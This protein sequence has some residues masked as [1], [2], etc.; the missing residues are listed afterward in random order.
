MAKT[1]E[2]VKG[3]YDYLPE[4][5]IIREHIKDTLKKVFVTY[6]FPPAETPIL[7]MY[8]LL[9]SKY[10]E[11]AD[12]L[13]EMYTLSDQ[14]K[15]ELGL[16]YDLTVC[17]SK[18]ISSNAGITLPLK[19]YEI[20]KVFRD[21]PVKLGRNREFTQCDVDVVGISSLL[22]EAE[23]MTLTTE[24]YQALG[25][26]VEILYNNRKLLS[27]VIQSVLGDME[28]DVLRKAIMLIDKLAK[29]TADELAKEFE[30]IGYEKKKFTKVRDLLLLDFHGLKE[31]LKDYPS[32]ELME[33]GLKEVE[34]LQAYTKD[35]P[36]E[37]T[38][39]FAPYLAR[40][41]D[42]YTGT[43]WEIFLKDRNMKGHDFNVSL[44]GGGRYDH[45]I[46]EFVSDGKEYP[47]VGMSFGLDVI[48]EV[49]KIKEE[50]KP[51]PAID[52][53]VMP[54]GTE[55]EAFALVSA[56]REKGVRAD[57]EK[58]GRR[59][60][61]SMNYANKENIPYVVVLGGDEVAN[62]EI[63]LKH[64]ES[65]EEFKYSIQDIEGIAARILETE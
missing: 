20:G 43:V 16:R 3:T 26:D 57:I 51:H 41:I 15:R 19:R 36:A 34:E 28:P 23:Y 17:F 59:V 4:E 9:A 13:N 2:T 21:G 32:N 45:I 24:A 54:I 49:L 56:L 1:F 53:F 22:Q 52:L 39:V 47:A 58:T 48:Y 61:K 33:E 60:K 27:G 5:Q 7:C 50:G 38:M 62:G 18:L 42:I 6:G 35:T 65:G 46:T 31:A 11:E 55:K 30:A 25:L 44:G 8:D 29:M 14:G 10:S 12:I 37:K 40:G 63:S 64:M